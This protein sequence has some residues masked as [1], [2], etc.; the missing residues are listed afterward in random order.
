MGAMSRRKGAS[1]EREL[2]AELRRL[3]FDGARRGRQY[4]GTPESPDVFAVPGWLIESKR[5]EKFSVY[6]ALDQAVAD[7]GVTNVPVVAHRRNGKPWVLIIKLDD[8]ESAAKAW[9][10]GKVTS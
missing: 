1:A 6:A 4:S 7:A 10:G 9:L 2:A 8:F 5:T 3:G